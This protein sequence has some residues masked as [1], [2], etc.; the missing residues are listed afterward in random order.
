MA[1]TVQ[2]LLDDYPFEIDKNTEGGGMAFSTLMALG[3]A[4][5]LAPPY[6]SK[7]R[8]KWLIGFARRVDVVKIT[9][10][11]FISKANTIPVRIYPKDRSIV[12]HANMATDMHEA[13]M[14]NSGLFKGFR[15]EFQRFLFDYLN[16][17]NGGFMLILG[18][19]QVDGPIVG[20][21]SGLVHLES[22]LCNRTSNPEY[23]VVYYHPDGKRYKIHYTRL[24]DMVSLPSTET[25]LN[26]VGLCPTSLCIDSA[27]EILDM[28]TYSQEKHGSR[29]A[30]QILYA[31]EGATIEQL[32]SAI[33][34]GEMKLDNEG[35][36]RFS[37][38][39][40]LAPKLPGGKLKLD[41]IDLAS[42]P[43]GFDR[44][45]VTLL[46]MAVIAS[47]FGLDLRDLAHSFG[48]S[49]QTRSDAEV[50]DRK[51]RG[52]GVGEFI[53]TFS[54]QLTQKF[55]PEY[56]L[57]SFDNLDDNQDEQRAKIQGIRSTARG[58]DVTTGIMTV[59]ASRH[60]MLRAGEIQDE[61]FDEMELTD[62]RLPD[63]NDILSLFYS[64][65]TYYSAA[66][67]IPSLSDPIDIEGNDPYFAIDAIKPALIK[68]WGLFEEE[69]NPVKRKKARQVIAALEKLQ[70][71]YREVVLVQEDALAQQTQQDASGE[72]TDDSSG[73]TSTN[74]KPTK[75][76]DKKTGVEKG[77]QSPFLVK[78]AVITPSG[79]NLVKTL[80]LHES[81]SEAEIQAAIERFYEAN[82]NYR[83][84]LSDSTKWE[85][86]PESKR[87]KNLE[88]GRF[89]GNN[90]IDGLAD[91]YDDTWEG[92]VEVLTEKL[93]DNGQE[94][95]DW[96]SDFLGLVAGS[97]LAYYVLGV[98]GLSNMTPERW[99]EVNDL[100]NDQINYMNGFA[101]DIAAGS[102]SA[103]QI[104]ART[105]MYF[106]S[107]QAAYS[108][109]KASKYGLILPAIPRDGSSECKMR[110]LCSWRIVE[111]DDR[112]DCTWSLGYPR[113]EHCPTCVSRSSTWNP[114]VVY[115]S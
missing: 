7:A 18:G 20:A 64:S 99:T 44:Q 78:A 67:K 73:S 82:P 29:P 88:T 62:G 23:P 35:H 52:K 37:K 58:R 80:P 87:F 31:S 91:R 98:G 106:A 96:L 59:R 25:N 12:R 42:S 110:C 15:H 14:R 81:Y 27:Q 85:Y 51:G 24:I 83:G 11:T 16:Q 101:S 3:A 10:K 114:Y 49:G 32:S 38:T 43:D 65:D 107:S 74:K 104:A 22:Y 86:D 76:S 41:L 61:D 21:A 17:D 30:R 63:G 71:A 13:L 45:T 46:D 39:L 26:G 60:Q 108:Y 9:V 94:L 40:L 50:Q 56:L 57:L 84:L 28:Y 109:G 103:A 66:L 113:T 97:I 93:V 5:H 70:E 19:G 105:A 72:A 100:V 112:W 92:D 33:Q 75:S 8:D 68:A 4:G 115:K 1:D 6:W 53:E 89:V 54:D 47:S 79:S 48:I 102:L 34:H 90:R 2:E 95:N 77:S 111:H 69:T 36:T 55:L